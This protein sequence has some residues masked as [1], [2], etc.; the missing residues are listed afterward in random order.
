MRSDRSVESSQTAAPPSR[1]GP[2]VALALGHRFDSLDLER[3]VLAGVARVVDGNAL[4]PEALQAE[5]AQAEAVLLGTQYRL[6]ADVIN[7]MARCRVIV[8]Y[9]AGVDNV[10]VAAA[11]ARGIQ[12]ANVPD[13]CVQEVSDHALA[14]LM[15]ASRRLPWAMQAARQG[16]WGVA[17]VRE[18]SRL[19]EQVVGV[20]GFGRVGRLFAGKARPLVAEV[21][22]HD[23]FVPDEEIH[24]A[25]FEPVAFE[26]LLARADYLSVH[27][28]L[29]EQTR[30]LLGAAAL[31]RMKP[32]AWLINTSRGEIVD[33]VALIQALQAGQLAGAALD[34]LAEEPPPPDHPLVQMDNVLLTPH[35]AY[36]SQQ[37]MQELKRRAAEQV[38]AVLTGG[39]PTWPVGEGGGG[40]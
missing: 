10:D 37:A 18:V 17:P 15:A 36:Y 30:H 13:Y 14:L 38:R 7:R 12:V 8:R 39:R 19:A 22:V 11:R 29:T 34:V 33:E 2:P 40:V 3:E 32:T 24:G 1:N 25:G 35:V 27:C 5:L 23:P 26:D 28:P 16:Q 31:A 4:S 20:L 21:L 6:T 9:G